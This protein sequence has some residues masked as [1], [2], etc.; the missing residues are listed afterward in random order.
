ML[1]RHGSTRLKDEN[2][3]AVPRRATTFVGR[4]KELTALR[5]LLRHARLITLTG[6]GGSGKTRLATELSA[7]VA[8]RFPHGVIFVDLTTVGDEQLVVD[9]VA[10]GLGIAST[11]R[12]PVRAVVDHL[13]GRRVLLVLDNCEHLLAPCAA[14]AAEILRCGPSVSLL[15]TSR[16]R[17]NIEGETVWSVPPLSLPDTRST[18]AA[19]ASDA[20]R[21]FVD[22]ARLVHPEFAL[23]E[24][25]TADVVAVCRAVDG[26]P[27]GIELAAAR[28]G[29][30]TPAELTAL[31]GDRLGTLVGGGRDIADRQRT[32]RATIAWSHD[33]LGAEQRVLFR[34]LAIFAGGQ[35]VDAIRDVCAGAPV[36]ADAV[37]DLLAQLVE[38]SVVWARPDGDAMRFG[39][40]LPIREFAA[41]RLRESGE[42]EATGAR[43]HGLYARLAAEAWEARL[44]RGARAEL[45]RLWHEADDVRSALAASPDPIASM[46]MT[47]DLF[48]V[49]LMH[50][51]NEGFR[52]LRDAFERLPDPPPELLARAARVLLA[53][54]GQTGDYS[55]DDALVPRMRAAVE[56]G[57][58]DSERPYQLF[59]LGFHRE[60]VAGDLAGARD[61]FSA[62]VDAFET[63]S[64]GPDLVLAT[65]EL[66][67]V[68]RQL[69]HMDI[70][71]R[72]IDDAL[73]RALR[74]DD[75]YGTIGAYFH[76][77]WI[78]LDEHDNAA[79][80]ASF[81][82]GLELADGSDRL[83]LA[84]QLEGVA[85][86][87]AP[88]DPRV[89]ARLFG[90]AE[91]LRDEAVARLQPPWQPRVERGIAETR[92]ALGEPAWSRELTAGRALPVDGVI[93]LVLER[94]ADR[95]A[96]GGLSRREVEVARLVAAGMTNR[97]IA[98][99]LFLSE[100]TVES[101]VDHVLTK[102]GFASR[103][104]I[105]A[106][107]A[108]QQL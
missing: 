42:I 43:H 39:M 81:A 28:L 83:S 40:L 108:G 25:N 36:A 96:T 107:V 70:A 8:A 2:R 26:I 4:R 74:I 44:H 9:S 89:A 92:D 57:G 63:E 45:Q 7:I 90:A 35:R 15:A 64:P 30:A 20:V 75:L 87:L 85:C 73:E 59:Q 91:R 50:A 31:L 33:L 94:T 53:C 106:W 102:L 19:D 93:A 24:R 41:E 98:G 6:A 46:E 51:P 3:A 47:A 48:F 14:L 80:R 49:W 66:G 77:G 86:A 54:A 29:A 10:S 99:K 17:L 22:R 12:D 76:R 67:S 16:E 62:A 21:L 1:R 104:Q 101:H 18:A 38:K 27:L 56:D 5:R 97:A 95:R 79:A 13:R 55:M 82:A 105:A 23:D 32:L 52:R 37:R 88:S 34:R 72:L 71:R 68:E 78:E 58:L 65:A 100:R 11:D 61:A 69:G 60:R 103:A 84:H